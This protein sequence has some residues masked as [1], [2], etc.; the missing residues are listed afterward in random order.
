MY[1]ST[2]IIAGSLFFSAEYLIV[3]GKKK[4]VEVCEK[5]PWFLLNVSWTCHVLG[6]RGHVHCCLIFR[7]YDL[8]LHWI[9]CFYLH[10]Y[11]VGELLP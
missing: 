6:S 11:H 2:V 10:G 7:S 1:L 9:I 4:T 3:M 5:R 8:Y